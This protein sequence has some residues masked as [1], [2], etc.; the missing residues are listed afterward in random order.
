MTAFGVAGTPGTTT[1]RAGLLRAGEG[2]SFLRYGERRLRWRITIGWNPRSSSR[3]AV[4][5]KHEDG[6]PA[7]AGLLRWRFTRG[8]T[9][10][11]LMRDGIS[12]RAGQKTY[13]RSGLQT[14]T[15][16]LSSPDEN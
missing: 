3:H 14:G 1:L 8:G 6:I 4:R 15:L 10:I 9:R 11:I 12:A 7:R 5:G 16:I 13:A 2:L